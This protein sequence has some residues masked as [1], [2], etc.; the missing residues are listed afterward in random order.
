MWPSVPALIVAVMV[1]VTESEASIRPFQVT[2]FVPTLAV[3]VPVVASAE[4][5][6]RSGDN[7]SVNSAPGL[8]ACAELLKF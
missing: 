3:A 6:V 2:V 8:S 1:I 4:T 7:T 5:K